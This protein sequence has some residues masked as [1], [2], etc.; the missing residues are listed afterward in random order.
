MN[1]SAPAK[2]TT[3]RRA[4]ITPRTMPS[5]LSGLRPPLA[6]ASLT[7]TGSMGPPANAG[8]PGWPP[9]FALAFG[10]TGRTGWGMTAVWSGAGLP[11]AGAPEVAFPGSLSGAAE[12]GVSGFGGTA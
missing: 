7:S 2:Y 12:P 8:W 9:G 6:S 10:M 11:G 1:T 4:T 3:A 5:T